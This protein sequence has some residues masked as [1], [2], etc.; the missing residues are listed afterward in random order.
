MEVHA[1]AHTERK[2]FTHYLWEFVMLFLAVFC[3]FLAENIR[4]YQVEAERG[5]QYIRSFCEDLRSDTTN[6]NFQINE[7]TQ[8][9]QV[10]SGIYDCFDS[11]TQQTLSTDCLNAIIINATGF[12]DFIY[13]DRTIQQLKYA[14]GL[15]LIK[16]QAIADSIIKYDANVREL[17]INQQVLEIQQQ[18]TIDAHNSMIGFRS[19]QHVNDQGV[20]SGPVLLTTDKREVNKYFNEIAIFKKGCLRQLRWIRNLKAMAA[21]M[22]IFINN[23]TG[24]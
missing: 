4:E 15:R 2:K 8:Q 16:D 3:G 21:R 11:V 10:L 24:E 12:T 19:L 1:H 18:N 14:G 20:R 7:L 9:D 17:Q 22:L 23:R 13:T 6:I 5:R